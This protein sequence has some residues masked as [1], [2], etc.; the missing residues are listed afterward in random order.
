MAKNVLYTV[1]V[2]VRCSPNILFEY[3]STATGLQ[4]WFA[5]EVNIKGDEL[6]FIWSQSEE[7]ATVVEKEPNK[8]I[9]FHWVESPEEEYFEFDVKRS[10]VTRET[11]LLITDFAEKDEI[12]DQTRLWESQLQDLFYHIGA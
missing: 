11:V 8:R 10:E 4:E 12:E 7:V 1:E 9:R 6:V 5:D 2:P 3:L